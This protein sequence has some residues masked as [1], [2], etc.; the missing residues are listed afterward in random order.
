MTGDA[1]GEGE[2]A[3]EAVRQT[4][5]VKKFLSENKLQRVE[6]IFLERQV[7]MV[8]WSPVFIGSKRCLYFQHVKGPRGCDG[9]CKQDTPRERA[10]SC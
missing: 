7:Q 2:G 6:K 10:R 5:D 4:I 9:R 8:A 3:P 1:E